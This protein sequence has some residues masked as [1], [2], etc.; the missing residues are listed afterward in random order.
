MTKINFVKM[1]RGVKIMDRSKY[2]TVS[3]PSEFTINWAAF[4]DETEIMTNAVRNKLDNCLN[5]NYVSDK[6]PKHTLDLYFPEKAKNVPVFIFIHGG[7]FVEGGKDDYGYVASP[8]AASN[9]ITIVP[10]YRLSPEHQY[11][12]QINDIQDVV[13]WVYHN[14]SAMGGDPKRIYLGG[15][16]AGAII[17]ASVALDTS[18]TLKRG[19][20]IDVVK[21]CFPISA[22]YDLRKIKPKQTIGIY[23]DPSFVEAASPILNIMNPPQDNL[24]AVGTT[25][26]PEETLLEPSKNLAEKLSEQGVRAKLL[27]LKGMNHAETVLSLGN[28]DGKLFQEILKI[29]GS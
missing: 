3:H 5:V 25:G 7:G 12:A 11:P 23:V 9:I 21:S 6:N 15:H 22:W 29:I 1:D 14:I 28:S 13:S 18:W 24:I 2:Y 20:P 16:S 19:L 8:F 10:S 26:A 17:S 27:V 4:Y